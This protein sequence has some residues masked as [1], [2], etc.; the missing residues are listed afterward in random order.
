[1]G[2]TSGWRVE[3]RLG[4]RRP[5]SA[6]RPLTTVASA[7]ARR[8]RYLCDYLAVGEAPDE[9]RNLFRQRSRWTKGHMQ[10]RAP[11]ARGLRCCPSQPACRLHCC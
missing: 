8:G 7:C 6:Q 10:V 3:G 5:S 9:A 4:R 2:R 1:M 11:P